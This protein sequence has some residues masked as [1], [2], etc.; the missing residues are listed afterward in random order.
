MLT[1]DTPIDPPGHHRV[2]DWQSHLDRIR[3]KIE[4]RLCGR[5]FDLDVVCSDDRIVLRGRSRTYYAKQLA[6]EM[7]LD[8]TGD[9]PRLVNEIVVG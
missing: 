3:C 5:I 4:C 9:T 6:Q 7:A 8:L 1:Q 2:G